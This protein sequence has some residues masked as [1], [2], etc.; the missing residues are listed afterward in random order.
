M[1]LTIEKLQPVE[2][3]LHQISTVEE[4]RKSGLFPVLLLLI[5]V[6]GGGITGWLWLDA[7]QGLADANKELNAVS[8]ELKAA[9]A[10]LASSPATGSI[11][12][13][14]PLPDEVRKAHPDAAEVLDKL[15]VL[16]PMDCNLGAVS[17]ADNQAVKVTGIFSTTESV[18]SFMQ[19]LKSTKDFTFVGMSGMTKVQPEKGANAAAN[20]SLPAVQVSFDLQYNGNTQKKG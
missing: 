6:V 19:S 16:V 2:I 10:K 3:N 7:K 8:E 11:A 17:F 18:I 13:F 4:K 1:N 14:L 15:A 5:A 12:E 20:A 9:Q